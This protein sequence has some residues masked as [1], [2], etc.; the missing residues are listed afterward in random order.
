MVSTSISQSERIE[1]VSV[2][3]LK[4]IRDWETSTQRKIQEASDNRDVS[5]K[6]RVITNQATRSIERETKDKLGA[7]MTSLKK[8]V[9]ETKSLKGRLEKAVS[10]IANEITLMNEKQAAVTDQ[11]YAQQTPLTIAQYRLKERTKRPLRENIHDAV[12]I[13]LHEETLELSGSITALTNH[14]QEMST[15]LSEMLTCNL[16]LQDDIL[17]KTSSLELDRTCLS[18]PLTEPNL[19]APVATVVPT[20]IQTTN[21]AEMVLNKGLESGNVRHISKHSAHYPQEWR[22]VTEATI[23]RAFALVKTARE[24]R[25]KVG[26]RMKLILANT[27]KTEVKTRNTFEDKIRQARKLFD[28]L[29][30]K[31]NEVEQE[32]ME[33]NSE[34][35]KIKAALKEKESP[36][37]H[38]MKRLALRKNRPTREIVRDDA[39]KCLHHQLSAMMRHIRELETDLG[40]LITKEENLCR[41]KKDLETDLHDK[42]LAKELDIKLLSACIPVDTQVQQASTVPFV[43][44]KGN[45]TKLPFARSCSRLTKPPSSLFSYSRPKTASG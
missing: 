27:K 17:D 20:P 43:L 31:L 41:L 38:C 1:R 2:R 5:C 11:L 26:M 33:I 18:L 25:K 10:T 12:Q 23:S 36:L 4:D 30:G 29:A 24:L 22:L 34:K 8:K 16:D 19:V 28:Q 44:S 42:S 15:V 45:I 14:S 3:G 9:A 21:Q 7:V 39:E 13:A 40:R 37:A 32:M 6:M 35:E